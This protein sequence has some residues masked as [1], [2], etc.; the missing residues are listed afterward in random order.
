M[1]YVLII[2]IIILIVFLSRSLRI[3][4]DQERFACFTLGQYKELK[5]PGL[6]FKFPDSAV[7]WVRIRLGNKGELLSNDIARFQNKDMPIISS[8]NISIGSIVQIT[9]FENNKINIQLSPNQTKNIIC[10]KCGH[11]IQI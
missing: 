2:I 4:Q 9:G 3:A 11:E 5:G 1:N 7:E 10:P 6:L 8:S